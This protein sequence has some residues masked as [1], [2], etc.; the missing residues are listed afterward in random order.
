MLANVALTCFD[1]FMQSTGEYNPMIRYADDFIITC[2]SQPEAK[3]TKSRIKTF[4]KDN[5]NLDLSDDK[6][7]I[8]HIKNGFDFLG[9]N[10]KKHG[11]KL[12]ITPSQSNI[13]EYRDSV[14]QITR[15]QNYSAI[16]M[17]KEL[18]PIVM[19][20]G[21]YY[22]SVVSYE[23]FGRNH[24]YLFQRL[25]KWATHKHTS[26]GAKWIMRKYFTEGWAFHDQ[27]TG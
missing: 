20:W 21:Q 17:I 11:D 16:T 8:T 7:H 25:Y 23:T 19:G 27:E 3:R 14:R 4:L 5:I 2:D 1:D 9:F 26:R 13:S 15:R 6:T 22:R 12:I 24:S 10:L 18:N